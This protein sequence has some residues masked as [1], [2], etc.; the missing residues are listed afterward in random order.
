MIRS[1]HCICLFIMS[2]GVC[3][4][5]CSAHITS[6]GARNIL[7]R[8]FS[9]SYSALALLYTYDTFII[10]CGVLICYIMSCGLLDTTCAGYTFSSQY[11]KIKFLPK[12][13]ISQ[14]KFSGPRKFTLRYK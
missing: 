3:S 8:A 1:G 12:L 6:Y 7:Y 9:I 4:G 5:L 11:L 14:S 13:P 10:L 2:C